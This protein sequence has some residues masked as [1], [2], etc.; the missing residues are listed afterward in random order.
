MKA[1]NDGEKTQPEQEESK[2]NNT[3]NKSTADKTKTSQDK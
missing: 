3:N 2:A 1:T